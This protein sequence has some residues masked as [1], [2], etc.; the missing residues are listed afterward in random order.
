VYVEGPSDK[1][2][3]PA[4]L[5]PVVESGAQKR[6][7]LQFIPTSG[8]ELLL[9]SVPRKAADHL[10]ENPT[11]WVFALPDLYPM[12]HYRGTPNQHHSLP[13]L[14][15]LLYGKF[16]GYA[17]K[18]ELSKDVR[19][20]FLVHC[21]K[22]DLE[23]FLLAA[24]APLRKRLGTSDHLSGAWKLPVEDQNDSKPPKRIVESLFSKYR[25]RNYQDTVDAPWI[26]ERTSLE[27]VVGAC[28][29]CLGPLVQE[30][31]SLIANA[32]DSGS[33]SAQRRT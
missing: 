17:D 25:K 14:Q 3:L 4:L 8:K 19:E 11:D 23:T 16:K 28:P 2:A 30:L 9:N 7:G 6:I 31:R 1:Y 10:S 32:P 21:L 27:E 33:G 26:L 24:V 29:Q 20:R 22:H 5:R 15:K 12:S 18:L 13:D